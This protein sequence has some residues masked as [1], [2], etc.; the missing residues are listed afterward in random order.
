MSTKAVFISSNETMRKILED[1]KFPGVLEL[2]EECSI[3]G[4]LE[5]E[6]FYSG[7]C[8]DINI[9]NVIDLLSICLFY[10]ENRITDFCIKFIY[11]HMSYELMIK[12]LSVIHLFCYNNMI[13]IKDLSEKY[14]LYNGY[15][16]IKN[17]IYFYILNN[18]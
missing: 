18:I 14:L 6:K 2:F 13:G 4:L 8:V 5:L 9:N 7:G 3:N 10:N 17:G 11:N 12:I 1:E 16:I 15:K